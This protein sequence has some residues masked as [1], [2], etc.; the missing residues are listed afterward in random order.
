MLRNYYIEFEG[1]V[2]GPYQL[3]QM[4]DLGLLAETL[5]CAPDEGIDWQPASNFSELA[6]YVAR[7]TP[8]PISRNAPPQAP[9]RN[10]RVYVQHSPFVPENLNIN[11]S[12]VFRRGDDFKVPLFRNI[13]DGIGNAVGK[14]A[15]CMASVAMVIAVIVVIALLAST[16]S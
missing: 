11:H 12:E 7:S 9:P 5:V 13:G 3:T 4:R 6:S 1:E 14:T 2:Y 10:S 16:C 15:G 8:P